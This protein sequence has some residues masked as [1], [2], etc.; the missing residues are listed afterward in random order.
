MSKDALKWLTPLLAAITFLL[1]GG[2]MVGLIKPEVLVLIA[3]GVTAIV[4]FL[5]AIKKDQPE[6]L[7]APQQA[8]GPLPPQSPRPGGPPK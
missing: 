6:H 5:A 4:G 7:P 3:A 2:H 1:D 8:Q